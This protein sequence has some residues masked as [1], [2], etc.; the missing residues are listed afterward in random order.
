MKI[1]LASRSPRRLQM[2][3]A[4]GIEVEVVEPNYVEGPVDLPPAKLAEH[5]AERKAMSVVSRLVVLSADTL[6]VFDGRVYGKPR[7][8]A[9]AFEWLKAFQ[10]GPQDVIT[11]VAV[12]GKSKCVF[13]ESS[14]VWLKC[15]RDEEIRAYHARVDPMD[16]AGACE[17]S[18]VAKCEGALDNVEGLPIA[19][20][21][22]ELRRAV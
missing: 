4:A 15:M 18:I 5:H 10:R 17:T 9:E 16:K 21:M 6:V 8:R 22:E 13:H 2:L 20:V 12:V 1:A 19:R 14:R 3:R 11:G 7:D